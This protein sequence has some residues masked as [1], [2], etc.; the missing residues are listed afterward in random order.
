MET[1]MAQLR[2]LQK[3][4]M[5]LNNDEQEKALAAVAEV[6]AAMRYVNVRH[7][8]EREVELTLAWEAEKMIVE[9]IAGD[10]SSLGI[11]NNTSSLDFDSAPYAFP[12][13]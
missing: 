3:K 6:V 11:Y 12:R 2:I 1:F 4:F 8:F 7:R 9:R 5:A 13:D 10:C